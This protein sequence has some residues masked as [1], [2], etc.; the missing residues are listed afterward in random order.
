MYVHFVWCVCVDIKCCLEIMFQSD[1]ILFG[2]VQHILQYVVLNKRVRSSCFVHVLLCS[3]SIIICEASFRII[4][5]PPFQNDNSS[6]SRLWC[7]TGQC[8][9]PLLASDWSA[10]AQARLWLADGGWSQLGTE[11]RLSP[12]LPSDP[13]THVWCSDH[14]GRGV[15]AHLISSP[16]PSQIWAIKPKTG[17]FLDTRR[18]GHKHSPAHFQSEFHQNFKLGDLRHIGWW[19]NVRGHVHIFN[20]CKESVFLILSSQ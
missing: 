20:S 5:R 19:P 13:A 18:G 12:R 2:F 10:S 16:L 7:Y 3:G 17:H 1:E 14:G 4:S 11:W 15:T 9:P 6:S 8:R